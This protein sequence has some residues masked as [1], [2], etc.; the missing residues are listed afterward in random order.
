MKIV[1]WKHIKAY[2]YLN[3]RASTLCLRWHGLR[4]WKNVANLA[5]VLY[6]MK[7]GNYFVICNSARLHD[8]GKIKDGFDDRCGVRS[9]K[10]AREILVLNRVEVDI[11]V[12]YE[13]ILD[14]NRD[15]KDIEFIESKIIKD[16]DRYITLIALRSP[17]DYVIAD[18]NFPDVARI[19]WTEAMSICGIDK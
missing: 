15:N 9:A 16:A 8:V 5:S 7:G 13:T 12:V 2:L 4:H 17:F 14:L 11:D 6:K 18:L 3:K 10:L 1:K 19:L